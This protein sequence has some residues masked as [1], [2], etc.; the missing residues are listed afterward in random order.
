MTPPAIFF[1]IVLSTVYGTAFHFWKGGSLKRL[2]LYVILSW[3]GFWTGHIVGG[4][5]GWSFAAAGPINAGMAT[6]GSAVFLFVGE[7]LSRVE[8]T[9]KK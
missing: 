8:I 5:L 4:A 2:F 6:L 9:N 3:L 1:G 7:W